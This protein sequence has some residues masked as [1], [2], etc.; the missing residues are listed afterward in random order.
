MKLCADGAV[1]AFP[2]GGGHA[3]HCWLHH[4]QVAQPIE[5]D[6][7]RESGDGN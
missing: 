4:P 3:A 6:A 1:P 2:L 7:T 5:M